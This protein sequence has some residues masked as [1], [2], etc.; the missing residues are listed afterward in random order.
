MSPNVFVVLWLRRERSGNLTAKKAQISF[1]S[2]KTSSLRKLTHLPWY[3]WICRSRGP[4]VQLRAELGEKRENRTYFEYSQLISNSLVLLCNWSL[5]DALW[6]NCP[7]TPHCGDKR[8]FQR[9]SVTCFNH[10]NP[11]MTLT[12]SKPFHVLDRASAMHTFYKCLLLDFVF[13]IRNFCLQI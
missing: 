7:E 2:W 8:R 11:N 1:H 12:P 4:R 6:F 5:K 3:P 13:Y 10:P 9:Q